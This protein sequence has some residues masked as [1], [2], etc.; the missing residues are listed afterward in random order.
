[1]QFASVS[2]PSVLTC[3]Y[4]DPKKEGGSYQFSIINQLLV[5]VYY[6]YNKKFYWPLWPNQLKK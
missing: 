2:F 3:E 1:M 6:V 4:A 5:N